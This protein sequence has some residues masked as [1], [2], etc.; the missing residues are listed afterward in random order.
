MANGGETPARRIFGQASLLSRTI[1]DVRYNEIDDEIVVPSPFADAILT[2]RGGADG[3]EAP[4]RI[5]QGPKAQV[6]GSR[7]AI[8]P[9]H[10][11][12]FAFGRDGIQVFPMGANGDVEPIRVIAGSNTMNPGSSIAVD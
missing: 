7:L 11:E 2:F 1:H 3:Q 9:V 4:I 12:I 5:I 6:G 10:K 8:D